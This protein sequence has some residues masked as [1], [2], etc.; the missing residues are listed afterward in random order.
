MIKT[1]EKLST[2]YDLTSIVYDDWANENLI[3]FVSE[4]MPTESA[5]A[6]DLADARLEFV[7]TVLATSMGI[8]YVPDLLIR[9][10]SVPG[11]LFSDRRR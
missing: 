2:T 5:S 9:N 6:Y 8:S 7:V 3:T 4:D 11:G 1:S 10:E